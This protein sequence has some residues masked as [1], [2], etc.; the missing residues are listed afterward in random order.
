DQDG[1]E[2]P[3]EIVDRGVAH[4]LDVA[5]VEAV[6]LEDEDPNGQRDPAPEHRLADSEALLRRERGRK[7]GDQHAQ[8]IACGQEP[9]E[10]AV[11]P[12]SLRR[13]CSSGTAIGSTVSSFG[14]TMSPVR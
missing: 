9:P 6:A 8:R 3:R 2:Q 7:E 10:P 5:V 4:A 1:M 14:V 11:A 13:K 12:G